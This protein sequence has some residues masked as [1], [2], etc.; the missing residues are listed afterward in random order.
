MVIRLMDLSKA[1]II[2]KGLELGLDYGFT[3]SCYEGG[4]KA[5]GRCDSCFH[6]LKGFELI[7]EKDP[8]EYE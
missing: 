4:E 5:C 2:K 7:G 6:R 3:W 1:E 8:I